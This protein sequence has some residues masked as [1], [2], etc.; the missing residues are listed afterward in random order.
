MGG[1]D[2][3]SAGRLLLT[4][5]GGGERIPLLEIST[6]GVGTGE[7]A[8]VG[9]V[10]YRHFGVLGQ[11][12]GGKGQTAV[13]EE[14]DERLVGA[15]LGKGGADAFLRQI[16]AVYKH[17]SIETRV[18]IELFAQ[19]GVAQLEVEGCVGRG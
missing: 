14:V 16:E 3:R 5:L 12:L 6:E 11:E 10:G 1:G 7:A 8:G 9:Y 18:E 15:A 13:G 2:L 4:E 17:L 19:D